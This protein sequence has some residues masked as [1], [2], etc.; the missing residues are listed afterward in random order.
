MTAY[1]VPFGMSIYDLLVALT[2]GVSVG[3][4]MI[5]VFGTGIDF[6]SGLNTV[7]SDDEDSAFC[8]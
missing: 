4:V 1:R 5:L 2:T 7:L 8:T 3:C 6:N